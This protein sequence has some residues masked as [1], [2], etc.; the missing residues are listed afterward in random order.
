MTAA[1]EVEGVSVPPGVHA[2]Q[3]QRGGGGHVTEVG[4]GQAPAAGAAQAG[5]GG[6]L[7]AVPSSLVDQRA[8]SDAVH[9]KA[10][11]RPHT[12]PYADDPTT[13]RGAV[14]V[15]VRPPGITGQPLADGALDAGAQ[16][17][18][19]RMLREN[20]RPTRRRPAAVPGESLAADEWWLQDL[21]A[22]LSMPSITLYAWTRRGWVTVAREEGRPACRLILWAD[23]A[24]PGRLRAR[25]PRTDGDRAR[26]AP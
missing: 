13:Q 15:V 23:R 16:G 24:E 22:E 3:V 5:N 1:G 25:R 7:R 20:G 18:V 2:D 19:R 8:A 26:L 21:A 9:R 10:E 11:G 6:G 4:P 17:V 12:G 14:A